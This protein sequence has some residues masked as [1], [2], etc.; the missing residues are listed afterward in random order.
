MDKLSLTTGLLRIAATLALLSPI[1]VVHA[2]ERQISAD[3][4]AGTWMF[5]ASKGTLRCDKKDGEAIG[6]ITFETSAGI[7]AVNGTAE[8]RGFKPLGAMWLEEESGIKVS[9]FD[10]V[11]EGNK[12][13]EKQ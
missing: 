7:F 8:D 3:T 6:A 12:L 2:G 13:C 4:F 10:T 11:A 9:R 1:G 5:V